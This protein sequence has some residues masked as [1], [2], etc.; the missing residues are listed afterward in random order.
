MSQVD[1]ND[2]NK[3]IPDRLKDVEQTLKRLNTDKNLSQQS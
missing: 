3:G 2:I 1:N